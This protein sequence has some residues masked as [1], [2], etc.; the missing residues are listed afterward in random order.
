MIR[1][2]LQKNSL[3]YWYLW[4][5]VFYGFWLFFVLNF[6]LWEVVKDNWAIALSMA[7]GSYVAGSTP[8]GGGTVGFPVLVLILDQPA[9][10]GRDFSFAV[11]AIG[12][13]S[14]SIFIF[15]RRQPV[16]NKILLGSILG[17]TIGVPMGILYIAPLI[18][19]LFIK[20]LFST[21]WASFGLLHLYRMNE[22][23]SYSANLG[24]KRAEFK[25]GFVL[26]LVFGVTVVAITGVGID[27][28]VYATLIFLCRTDL[29]ISIPTSV[30]IMAYCSVLG[31]LVKLLFTGVESGVYENWLAAAPVV[32]LGAPL[33]VYAVSVIGRKPTI[34]IVAVLCV[35][36]FIWTCYTEQSVLGLYGTIA[37]VLAVGF[38]VWIFEKLRSHGA[39]EDIHCQGTME[40]ETETL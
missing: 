20:I 15:A 11:Q 6:D 9:T 8:M 3:R 33:G 36:Q 7:M 13:T 5:A 32:A 38:F 18:S 40:F 27:L 16:A 21:I 37:T 24:E 17:A 28:F 30:V 14:A 10:L 39:K 34:L 4:L 22:I 31:I 23:S 25:L 1:H 12:M 19:D 26:G 29:R 35:L 2:L